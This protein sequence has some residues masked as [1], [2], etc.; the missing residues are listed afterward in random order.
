MDKYYTV[1]DNTEYTNTRSPQIGFG[2][3]DENIA[4]FDN[5]YNNSPENI[6]NF[7]WQTGDQSYS[8]LSDGVIEYPVTIS[9]P[10]ND[11]VP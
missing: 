7:A 6:A 4:I 3:K 11:A 1:F 9:P 5:Q 2:L 10:A 8:T